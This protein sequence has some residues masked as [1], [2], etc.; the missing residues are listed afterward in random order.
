[1]HESEEKSLLSKIGENESHNTDKVKSTSLKKEERKASIPKTESN[2]DSNKSK[3]DTLT[4]KVTVFNES[5]SKQSS[6][7][8]KANSSNKQSN[9]TIASDEI[10]PKIYSTIEGMIVSIIENDIF[11][12]VFNQDNKEETEPLIEDNVVDIGNEIQNSNTKEDIYLTD[13]NMDLSISTGPLDTSSCDSSNELEKQLDELI[14][15]TRS[16]GQSLSIQNII[17]SNKDSLQKEKD[18]VSVCSQD[19]TIQT[20]S[21]SFSQS[22]K[23]QNIGYK[24]EKDHLDS[25]EKS[26]YSERPEKLPKNKDENDESL[27]EH[28]STSVD[29]TASTM[30]PPISRGEILAEVVANLVSDGEIDAGSSADTSQV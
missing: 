20:N 24:K 9:I 30:P 8:G 2:S 11:S 17:P 13:I 21:F 12:A 28:I 3:K 1:M 26:L 29:Y 14:V 27:N 25:S 7:Y 23:P 22:K 6:S 15:K 19:Q 4:S 10:N 18:P 16:N 5:S